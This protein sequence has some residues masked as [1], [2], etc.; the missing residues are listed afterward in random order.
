MPV[1]KK[2]RST[3]N[4]EPSTPSD[5][6]TPRGQRSSRWRRGVSCCRSSTHFLTAAARHMRKNESGVILAI[7]AQVACSPYPNAGGF[8]V[9][10]AA[11]E[12]FCRQLAAATP[13]GV[14]AILLLAVRGMPIAHECI[15]STVGTVK[16]DRYH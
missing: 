14:T 13:A 5:S 4:P 6:V 2:K 7:T 8:G 10:C 9:A 12:G 3:S 1:S 16:G 11:I 15:A